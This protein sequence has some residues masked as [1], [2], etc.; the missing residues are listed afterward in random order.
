MLYGT[1]GK[2][3]AGMRRTCRCCLKKLPR[4]DSRH[5]FPFFFFGVFF[6]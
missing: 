6:N 4:A 1:E 5:F 3:E 2:R